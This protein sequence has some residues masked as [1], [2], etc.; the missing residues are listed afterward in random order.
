[1]SE[2]ANTELVQKLYAAFGRG[3]VQTILDHLS[4]DVEWIAEGPSSLPFT[5]RR[6]GPAQVLGFFEALGG[7]QTGQK[8]TIDRFVAQGDVVA[9]Y[10]RY[11]GTVNATGKQFDGPLA[12]FFTIRGGKVTEFIDIIDTAGGVEAYSMSVAA[13]G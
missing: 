12:H 3:D 1:M 10:G 2:Q 9:T 11:A 6:K 4:P 8:L 7:T 5:G 13:A